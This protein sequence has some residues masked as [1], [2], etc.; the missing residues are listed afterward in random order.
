M[1]GLAAALVADPGRADDVAQETMLA[2]LERPPRRAGNLRGWLAAVTRNLARRQYRSESRRRAREEAVARADA[3][4]RGGRGRADGGPPARRCG[5]A[6]AARGAAGRRRPAVL[7]RTPAGCDIARIDGV[8]EE[9]VRSRVRRGLESIRSASRESGGDRAAWALPLA[10]WLGRRPGPPIVATTTLVPGALAVTAKAK[11]LVA[12]I[13]VLVAGAAAWRLAASPDATPSPLHH[14]LSARGLARPGR[15]GAGAGAEPASADAAANAPADVAVA[16]AEAGAAATAPGRL[17]LL[18]GDSRGAPAADAT[19]TL[20]DAEE[21]RTAS[22]RSVR[23][24]SSG[25]NSTGPT[26]SPSSAGGTTPAYFPPSGS[27]AVPRPRSA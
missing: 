24:A 5:G 7:R 1:R 10:A 20:V 26:A 13:L 14:A 23:T 17:R 2:A 22:F 19:V 16:D 15:R 4:L 27:R 25:S 3:P 12:A 9:T 6:R 8:P 21:S 11:I 18:V